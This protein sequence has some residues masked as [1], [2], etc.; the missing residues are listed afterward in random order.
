MD[1]REGSKPSI[2][3]P[4]GIWDGSQIATS[5]TNLIAVWTMMPP[6]YLLRHTPHPVSLLSSST[7]LDHFQ[8]GAGLKEDMA[9]I[10][11]DGLTSFLVPFFHE[12]EPSEQTFGVSL[13]GTQ[14]LVM[15]LSPKMEDR[16]CGDT[17]RSWETSR[18]KCCLLGPW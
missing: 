14:V 18:V 6:P 4:T 7:F 3:S 11:G 1:R 2:G 12:G 13:R 15:M 16:G 10:S 8:L 9:G 17:L 5:T